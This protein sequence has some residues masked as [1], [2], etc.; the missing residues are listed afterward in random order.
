M[1][2]AP[3]QSLLG[4]ALLLYLVADVSAAQGQLDLVGA[5]LVLLAG[6]LALVPAAL[7]RRPELPGGARV[8]FLSLVTGYA[9]VRAI[10]PGGL[11]L[12][13]DIAAALGVA[14]TG[15]LVLDLA[16]TVPEHALS[17]SRMRLARVG[18]YAVGSACAAAGALAQAPAWTMW[19][20][21]WIVNAWLTSVPLACATLCADRCAPIAA[22]APP[23]WR[24][25]RIVGIEH[26]GDG[27]DR[28]CYLLCN[29]TVDRV[30][31]G[32]SARLPM[33]RVSSGLLASALVFSHVRLVDPARR[34]SVGPTIRG[35]LPVVL[36]LATSA[37]AC[38]LLRPLWPDDPLV[39]GVA[40]CGALLATSA[41]H[42][43]LH[44]AAQVWL[45]P[46]SGRVLRAFERAHVELADTCDLDGVARV[47]LAA[48]REASGD[49]TAEPLLYLVEP[50][51]GLRA[52]A[53]GN[54][55]ADVRPMHAELQRALRERP[56]RVLLRAQL[57]AQNVRQPALR[58]LIEVLVALD[59][60]CVVPLVQRG[61]LEGALV[62]PRAARRSGLTLEEL[63]AV[64]RFGRHLTGFVA[65]LCAEDRAQLRAAGARLA[66]QRAEL[67]FARAQ[68]E[69]L[70]VSAEARALRAGFA[71]DPGGAPLLAYSANMRAVLSEVTSAAAHGAPL[72]LVAERGLPLQP[73]ARL[74]HEHAGRAAQPFVV[75]DGAMMRKEHCAVG[76]F[77]GAQD[78][79]VTPGA[80]RLAADGTLFV[81][82]LP[83]LPQ[84]VQ[85]MLARAL[86]ERRARPAD[87]GDDYACGARVVASCR[88]DP[89]QLV[90]DGALERELLDC[91]AAPL[92]VP[93]LRERPEDLPSLLLLA[94]DHSARVLGRAVVG[95]EADA[96][97]RLVAH[98]WPGN[99]DE[100]HAV[101]ELAF[102][103]CTGA[104][105]ASADLPLFGPPHPLARET[106]HPLD[107]TL[108]RVERRVLVRALER[109]EGNK[110]EAARLLGLPRTTF[111]D[112][113]RRYGLEHATASSPSG[114]EIN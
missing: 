66:S 33:M 32:V 106:G 72:L 58:S 94:I 70:R 109:A 83:A 84:P 111:L 86:R 27:R 6:A 80:L 29:R 7:A 79:L 41:L 12:A 81:S 52:D 69:L 82:D 54:P 38:V 40:V 39:L 48:A 5:L 68:A 24:D 74:A 53:A 13:V 114:G 96:Q 43:L 50:A 8:G 60:L 31:L 71:L 20:R 22:A 18:A 25:A 10:A 59:A 14:A 28:A 113:V 16:L 30:V 26:V 107:G 77:G 45:A 56:G 93:P 15:T 85:C 51:R 112:K 65:L 36:A 103:R 78:A 17:E 97:E 44:G 49:P 2:R 55:H 95:L 87:G 34:L 91:F 99:L 67:E 98:D 37:G 42:R 62:V 100:L 47:A 57:E 19:N 105:I 64:Q 11:S 4:P 46:A 76:L 110:S 1:R 63:E 101:V 92:R 61:E 3:S 108:E 89:Q 23:S 102:V 104:R 90:L 21:V 73:L 9:F 88:R 75:F 35:A